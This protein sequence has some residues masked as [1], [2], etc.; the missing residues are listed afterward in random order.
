MPAPIDR[1]VN[2]TGMYFLVAGVLCL[3]LAA[4]ALILPVSAVLLETSELLAR[5]PGWLLGSILVTIAGILGVA[6]IVQIIIAWG[7]WQL[8]PWARTGAMIMAVLSMP[9]VP[10]GTM[11]GGFVLYFLLQDEVRVLFR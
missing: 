11:A 2:L 5:L 1:R 9:F 3:V 10:L 7:L 8:R 6:G 4:A